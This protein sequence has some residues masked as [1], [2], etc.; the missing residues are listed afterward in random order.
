MNIGTSP[1]TNKIYAGK[2]K[3]IGNGTHQW[4]GAKYDITEDAIRAVFEWF[5][6]N[7]K[8]NEPS[9]AFEIRFSGCAYVLTMTKDEDDK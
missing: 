8:K 3:D 7:H 2:S 6:Q 4:V 5:M 1:L 9:A